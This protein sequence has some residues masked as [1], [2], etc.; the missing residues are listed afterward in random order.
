MRAPVRAFASGNRETVMANS[1]GSLLPAPSLFVAVNSYARRVALRRRRCQ[2][3]KITR[4]RR[5]VRTRASPK[6]SHTAN[7]A[8]VACCGSSTIIPFQTIRRR[9]CTAY[10]ACVCVCRVRSTIHSCVR[11]DAIIGLPNVKCSV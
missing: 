10:Y 11:C 7:T 8:R 6:F 5:R 9:A 3:S 2:L 4:A 1:F